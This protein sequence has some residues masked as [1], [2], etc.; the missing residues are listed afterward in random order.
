MN[1]GFSHR[2]NNDLEYFVIPSFEETELVRHC[3]TTRR[4]GVTEGEAA[5]LNLS[6]KRKDTKE[7]VYKNFEIICNEIGINDKKLILSDQVHSDKI[8]LAGRKDLGKGLYAESDIKGYDGLMAI[9]SGVPLCTF[10]ADCV[11]LF[12]LDTR[13]KIV[14][15]VHSGWRSTLLEIGRKTIEKM[16]GKGSRS[17]DILAA[18]GPSIGSCHFE[19]DQDV[20]D[21]FCRKFGKDI[22]KRTE[23][24]K[25]FIDL[26][27]IN[28]M[29]F[30]Q[31]G[32][33][34]KNITLAN[35]CTYCEKDLFYS[36]R[37]DQG[38]TG[39][40]AALIELR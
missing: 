4:G 18:I 6:F 38:K 1:I 30:M 29:Q 14:A 19:V 17:E 12:F 24:E 27:E 5:S 8:Y 36:Y 34:D 21:D 25:S 13:L 16:K 40:L 31:Q 22:V 33:T 2:I 15:T 28:L 20:S 7:N 3:F 9:E 32:I 37:G 26:W 10:Y 35:R 23:N 11:P 39:S